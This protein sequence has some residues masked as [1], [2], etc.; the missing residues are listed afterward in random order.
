MNKI[1]F[2]LS[3]ALV[4]I[5]ANVALGKALPLGGLGAC[6]S[7]TV[8]PGLYIGRNDEIERL[9]MSGKLDDAKLQNLLIAYTN[10]A[11]QNNKD[12]NKIYISILAGDS[13][14]P[15]DSI[16]LLNMALMNPI[17]GGD[18]V[19]GARVL[20]NLYPDDDTYL[21]LEEEDNNGS[22]MQNC[23]CKLY[24]NPASTQISFELYTASKAD[25][26]FE[27]QDILGRTIQE[28]SLTEHEGVN[29]I[30]L[31]TNLANG[32]Y[33]FRVMNSEAGLLY[34]NKLVISK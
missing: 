25:T 5:A 12:L 2:K 8:R 13:V 17:L 28:G 10:I 1:L 16:T 23:S 6:L 19:F 9:I 32:A 27:L 24:P 26:Y 31:N 33:Y 7:A 11:E 22:I 18:A 20:L 4:F 3:L 34:Q 14:S 30:L 15:A 29:D 21:R